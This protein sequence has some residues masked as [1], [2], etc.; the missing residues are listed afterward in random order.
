[1]AKTGCWC[2]SLGVES[3]NEATLKGIKKQITL[4]DVE[5]TCRLL[6]K[7]GIKVRAHFM[8]YNVWEEN[9]ELFFE[10]SRMSNDT[11]LYAEKLFQKGWINY[12]TWSVTIPFR[13]ANSTISPSVTI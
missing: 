1:M 8:L 3:A 13:A 11:L 4:T 12:L 7:H 9:G 6:R 2:V 5:N 10:D